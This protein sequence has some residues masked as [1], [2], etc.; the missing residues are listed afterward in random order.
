MKPSFLRRVG[1]AALLGLAATSAHAQSA[2]R[3]ALVIGEANYAGTPL[4]TAA[5]DAALVSQTLSADGFDVSEFHDLDRAGLQANVAAFLAK[6]RAAPDGA[7]V[8][9]YLSGIGASADCDDLLLPVDARIA[10]AGDV[11]KIGLSMTKLMRELAATK[12]AVRLVMLDGARPAPPEVSAVDLPRGLLPL[13]APE[14]TTFGLSAEAHDFEA[15]PK[16]GD[17][18]DAYA[19]AFV[20]SA[21][22]P[23]TDLETLMRSIRLTT[24]QSTDG[25]QTPW[26]ET[27]PTQ[28][29]FSFPA[30]VDPA[31]AEAVAATLPNSTSPIGKLSASDAYTA[32]IWRNSVADYRAYIEAFKNSAPDALLV[33]VKALIDELK[34]VDPACQAAAA[35]PPPPPHRVVTGPIC[36]DGFF[37]EDGYNGAYCQPIRRPP[38]LLCPPGYVRIAGVDDYACAPIAPPPVLFCPPGFHAFG[39]LDRLRRLGLTPYCQPDVPPP[40]VCPPSMHRGFH[41]GG[42]FC[43]YDGPPPPLCPPGLHPIWDRDGGDYICLPNPIAPPIACPVDGHPQWMFDH[44]ICVS[45]FRNDRPFCPPGAEATWRDGQLVCGILPPPPPECPPGYFQLGD[46]GTC[47]PALLPA[48]L[49]AAAAAIILGTQHDQHDNPVA[50]CPPGQPIVNGQC[51]QPPLPIGVGPLPQRPASPQQPVRTP[52]AAPLAQPTIPAAS[53]PAQQPVAKPTAV[54]TPAAAPPPKAMP[55][56]AAP[57]TPTQPSPKLTPRPEPTQAQPTP[58]LTPKIAPPAQPAPS[59]AA[60]PPGQLRVNGACVTSPKP[61]PVPE[62]SA[63][64]VAPPK[65]VPLVVP[66]IPK[67]MSSAP[68]VQQVTPKITPPAPPSAPKVAPIAPPVVVPKAAPA[69]PPKIA[70]PTP[71]LAPKP[72]PPTPVTA[73]KVM[74]PAPPSAPKIAPPTPAL[75]PKPPPAAPVTAPKVTPPAPPSAPKVAP[76]APPVVVPKAAPAS[77]PTVAP[78]TPALAPKPLPPTPVTAP[79]ATPSPTPTASKTPGTKKAEKGKPC[80]KPGLPECP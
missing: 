73:P 70:P 47:V 49:P 62:P 63:P 21:A 28:P 43:T 40:Y 71:T 72:P 26:Q 25:A 78:P 12:S 7:A 8:T 48:L 64:P 79:K 75:A 41:N 56:A 68:T 33:R 20:G 51:I 4:P 37:P 11:A 14:A 66:A 24:H 39:D 55:P 61:T 57:P 9:V 74:A 2:N 46:R 31:Q 36:P 32:V 27:N 65:S 15:P 1:M 19:A 30:A 6:V 58:Q 3:L 22:Q 52:A 60:C 42:L 38:V 80:G 13:R 17:T 10:A 50:A 53:T 77:A 16:V 44:W 59:I 76:I 5:N 34:V 29:S 69:S 54:I 23:F 67:A 45:D 35:P 18:N